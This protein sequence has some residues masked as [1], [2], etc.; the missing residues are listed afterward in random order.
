LGVDFR[1]GDLATDF[2]LAEGVH[3]VALQ[4][5]GR[6]ATALLSR[7][8]AR[9]LASSS[10][11]LEALADPPARTSPTPPR[12]PSNRRIGADSR[13]KFDRPSLFILAK[14]KP[15]GKRSAVA[16]GEIVR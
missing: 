2:L 7:E 15:T 12:L 5:A 3:A 9:C 6:G 13:G 10:E 11:K 4:A 14:K 16:H 1:L 8:A